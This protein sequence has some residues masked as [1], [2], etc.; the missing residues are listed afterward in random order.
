MDVFVRG[1]VQLPWRIARGGVTWPGPGHAHGPE[2]AATRRVG[3]PRRPRR[4]RRARPPLASRFAPYPPRNGDL[5]HRA[6]SDGSRHGENPAAHARRAGGRR[7]LPD[8]AVGEA[9]GSTVAR[10]SRHVARPAR[11][12]RARDAGRPAPNRL[13]ASRRDDGCVRLAGTARTTRSA[14]SSSPACS[15]TT[16]RRASSQRLLEGIAART[17]MFLCCEPRRSAF[18]LAGSRLIGL[19][20]AGPVTRQDAVSSVHAGFR[21]RELSDL[22]PSPQDW[23]LDEYP[24]GLFSHCFLAVRKAR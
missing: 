10:G 8:A 12:G 4:R 23:V 13:D 17:R 15:S 24:A 16:F 20:G 22:W 11:Y 2:P 5:T 18:A 9:A 3:A 21:A 6:A 19:L 1:G 7:R 14:M